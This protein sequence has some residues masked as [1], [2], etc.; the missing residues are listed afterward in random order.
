MINALIGV[1]IIGIM[2]AMGLELSTKDFVRM[3]EMPR[4]VVVGLL[5]QIVLLPALAFGLA[6]AL[7]ASPATAAGMVILA[8]CPGGPPSNVLSY[9]AGAHIALSVTLTALSSLVTVITVP[10]IVNLGLAVFYD[11]SASVRLPIV[12]TLAQLTLISILPI[13]IGIYIRAR[14]TERVKRLQSKIKRASLTVFCLAAIVIVYDTWEEFELHFA[15]AAVASVALCW[16]S[17][18]M[19]YAIASLSRLDRRDRFTIALEVGVQNIA[20]SSL[21]ILTQ[22]DRPELIP[23]PSAYAV[24]SLPSAVLLAVGFAVVRSRE[25]SAVGGT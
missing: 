22:L 6:Y 18:A 16:S 25:R 7:S 3:I 1:T 13:G 17:L 14:Y 10:F 5:A 9:L 8:A 20:L 24:V 19:G 15:A 4:A 11:G 12:Q 2:F 23:L 21:I